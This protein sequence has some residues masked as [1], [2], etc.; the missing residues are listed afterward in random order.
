MG[1]FRS[2][3]VNWPFLL[4]DVCFCLKSPGGLVQVYNMPFKKPVVLLFLP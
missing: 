2:T 3:Q 4:K 1:G